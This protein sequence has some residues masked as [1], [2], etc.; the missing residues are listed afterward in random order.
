MKTNILIGILFIVAGVCLGATKPPK[1]WQDLLPVKPNQE[2]RGLYDGSTDSL[3]AAISSFRRLMDER[4]E[5][6]S[7]LAH[8]QWRHNQLINGQGVVIAA[9]KKEMDALRERV[10][11]LEDPNGPG[12]PNEVEK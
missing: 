11:A 6:D 5:A 12:D 10:A 7:F 1:Y 2:W 4:Y 9:M 8:G 3:E